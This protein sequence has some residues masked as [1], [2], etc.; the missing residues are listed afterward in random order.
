MYS[1]CHKCCGLLSCD[2]PNPGLYACCCMSHGNSI[3]TFALG[4]A[5]DMQFEALVQREAMYARQVRS[6]MYFAALCY[7][8]DRLAAISV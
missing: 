2:T 8:A 3:G 4:V 7:A 1:L 6:P 5:A